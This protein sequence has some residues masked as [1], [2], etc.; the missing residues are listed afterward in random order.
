MKWKY[1]LFNFETFLFFNFYFYLK[2]DLTKVARIVQRILIYSLYSPSVNI[3]S[4]FVCFIFL[5]VYIIFLN[6]FKVE[7]KHDVS[8]LLNVSMYILE[9]F[10]YITKYI[11]QNQEI[12]ISTVLSSTDLNQILLIIPIIFVK[13]SRSCIAFICHG[14]L[15]FFPKEWYLSL[16]LCFITLMFL[17]TIDIFLLSVPEVEFDGFSRWMQV[18]IFGRNT[19]AVRSCSQCLTAGGTWYHFVLLLVIF[20]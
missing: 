10:S 19:V 8:L 12:N 17:E 11:G 15:V 7:S 5:S 14:F 3:L 20:G 2:S 18:C 4:F 6:L 1:C 9:T 16:Y 13:T